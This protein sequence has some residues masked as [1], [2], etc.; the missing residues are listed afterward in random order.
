MYVVLLLISPALACESSEVAALLEDNKLFEAEILWS[1]D[2]FVAIG[3]FTNASGKE[4][5][6]SDDL[7]PPSKK[8]KKTHC[9]TLTWTVLM[10]NVL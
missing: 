4:V 3:D 10:A 9:S 1:E 8:L 7:L 2:N 6:V 5:L